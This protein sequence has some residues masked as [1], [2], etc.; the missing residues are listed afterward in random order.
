[1]SQNFALLPE[2]AIFDDRLSPVDIRVLAALC[3]YGGRKHEGCW[4][5]HSK[6][7][8]RLKL[9]RSTVLR[10]CANLV[11][12]EFAQKETRLRPDGSR[13]TNIYRIRFE[14]VVSLDEQ[15]GS[16]HATPVVAENPHGGGVTGATARTREIS[17]PDKR[18]IKNNKK[19]IKLSITDWE[20]RIGSE[21]RIEQMA[22][23]V[24]A[25]KLDP[26]K[27]KRMIIEFRGRMEANGTMYADFVAAFKDWMR[28]DFLTIKLAD[29]K[30]S[31]A[32]EG[33]HIDRSLG[34]K[35]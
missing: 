15:G 6:I 23:W 35:L 27:I 31:A 29:S 8:T 33:K 32:V 20:N 9:S 4:P 10:S 18:I 11:K 19:T 28:R 16:T 7:A 14:L 26:V 34:V 24:E 30:L 12:C 2:N 21:L 1:M 3:S 13:G 17:E 25:N 22:A 5:S